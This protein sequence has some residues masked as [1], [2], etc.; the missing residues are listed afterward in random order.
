MDLTVKVATPEAFVVPDTVVIVSLAPREEVRVTVFPDT[1]L[2]VLSSSVTVIVEVVE[3]SAVIELVD[4]AT[5]ESEALTP[6]EVN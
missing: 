6:P 1:G 2:E 3:P 5:V 4:E